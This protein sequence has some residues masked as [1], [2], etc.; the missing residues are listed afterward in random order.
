M[1]YEYSHW[2]VLCWL[3]YEIISSYDSCCCSVGTLGITYL[4]RLLFLTCWILGFCSEDLLVAQFFSSHMV[5]KEALQWLTAIPPQVP[6]TWFVTLTCD[7]VLYY[8]HWTLWSD[9]SR[10]CFPR[11]C[12]IAG[13]NGNDIYCLR[14]K[15][16]IL[17][18]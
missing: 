6:K 18:G 5:L 9:S 10:R 1:W 3:M 11:W 14:S 12:L 16:Q 15:Y 2:L 13:E 7:L 17:R 4:I 8:L